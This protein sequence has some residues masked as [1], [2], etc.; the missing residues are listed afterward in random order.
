MKILFL[1]LNELVESMDSHNIILKDNVF[2][3][4]KLN[5]FTD[6]YIVHHNDI[7]N[8]SI[9]ET[10]YDEKI[11]YICRYLEL[12]TS[13]KVQCQYCPYEGTNATLIQSIL[14]S[15]E[16]SI[17]YLLGS[18]IE[19]INISERFNIKYIDSKIL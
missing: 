5:Q 4:I 17:C 13:C 16:N 19:D 7:F 11:N 6:I 12:S 15:L 9:D 8:K 3:Y 2:N 1:D 10:L 18:T 14:N